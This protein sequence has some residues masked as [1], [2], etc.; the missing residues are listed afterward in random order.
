MY[1]MMRD[2]QK[3]NVVIYARVSTEHEAQISALENQLDWYKPILANHPEW[4]LVGRYVDEGITGTSAAKRPQFMKMMKDAKSHK[5]NMILTREV[6]RFARN[7][8][9]TLQYTR[10]LHTL[11]VEVYFIND[12]IRTFDGDGELRLTIMATLAQDESRKTSVRVKA[13][14]QTAMENG[15]VYGT[16]N[17]LGYDRIDKEMVLNEEQAKTVRLIYDLYLAGNG[18]TKIR[19]ELERRGLK[20]SMGKTKWNDSGISRILQNPFYC[21]IMQY[22]KYYTPDFLEQKRV[23]NRGELEPLFVRGKHTPIV[24]EKEFFA[25]Q[26]LLNEK[27][28][29]SRK[30]NEDSLLRG[31]KLVK[32]AWGRLLVC[33]CGKAMIRR[34]WDRR[35]GTIH[36]GYRCYDQANKGTTQQRKNHSLSTD[37]CCDTPY[38]PQWKLEMIAAYIFKN[39]ISESD[40]VLTLANELLKKHFSERQE[41]EDHSELIAAKEKE[42]EKLKRK[43]DNYMDMRS[44]GEITKE[45]FAE[46]KEELERKIEILM[47]EIDKAKKMDEEPEERDYDALLK[48]LKEELESYIEFDGKSII[49]DNILEA[50]IERIVVHKD[51][52]DWHLRLNGDKTSPGKRNYGPT[53]LMPADEFKEVMAM[54]SMTPEP[55]DAEDKLLLDTFSL[56]IEDAKNYVYAISSRRRVYHWHDLKIRLYA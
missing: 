24:S 3:R 56:T 28:Y 21:G 23:R 39:Y 55:P 40:R 11:G 26:H 19:Y 8:V 18:L 36:Y 31:K 1:D 6:S 22:H 49:P 9:D 2:Y 32:T 7:T 20:T 4:K 38:I 50:F 25:V 45:V 46:K 15:V 52:M 34:V 17:I 14:I 44:D 47:L 54:L 29:A 51:G 33:D 43:L 5:Y 41:K 53:E 42:I 35:N 27:R 10:M 48:S 30:S 16:G 13:G 37:G 12:N